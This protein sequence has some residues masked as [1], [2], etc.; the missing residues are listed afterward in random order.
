MKVTNNTSETLIAFSYHTSYGYGNDFSIEPGE[1][2]ELIGPCLGEM[3]GEPCYF[4]GEGQII[5]QNKPDD[6]VGYYIGKGDPLF[7]FSDPSGVIV[8]HHSEERDVP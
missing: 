4:I 7:L 3:G 2:K 5:C 8:R 6:E 1:T